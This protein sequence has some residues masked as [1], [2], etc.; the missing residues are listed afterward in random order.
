MIRRA[1]NAPYLV[2]VGALI[3]GVM[4]SISDAKLP[5]DLLPT[6]TNRSG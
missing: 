1:L 5:A 2:I 4:G 6:F 3:L